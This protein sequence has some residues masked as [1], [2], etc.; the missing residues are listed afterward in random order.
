MTLPKI[1]PG[2]LFGVRGKS[3]L[4]VG[5]TGAFGSVAC[6]ALAAAGAKLTVTAGN[7]EQLRA[8][9]AELEGTTSTASVARRPNSEADAEAMVSAAVLAHGGIDIL[10]VAS[11]MNDVS[12][13]VD[14]S[15]ERFDA[16]M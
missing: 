8:L 15:R 1:D 10:V 11:G 9:C 14:M 2:A 4:V 12:P 5:A 3:A 16:V 13:I 7:A 6:A